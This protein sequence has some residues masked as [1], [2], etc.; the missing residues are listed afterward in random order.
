[1]EA[2]KE[3]LTTKANLMN[4]KITT[5]NACNQCKNDV[6]SAIHAFLWSCNYIRPIWE[7]KF[8]WANQEIR[9]MSQFIDVVGFI[10]RENRNK[11]LFAMSAW[12][13][14]YRQNAMRQN[15]QVV[16]VNLVCSNKRK[17]WGIPTPQFNKQAIYSCGTDITKQTS[18]G[19]ILKI[20]MKLA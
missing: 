20:L 6:E 8:K 7:E 9:A 18:N 10:L 1:M 2:C 19:A 17:F 11:D 12:S 14:W 16:P 3:A 5:E 4:R 13:I 15:Q